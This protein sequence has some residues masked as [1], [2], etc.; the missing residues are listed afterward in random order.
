MLQWLHFDRQ[1]LRPTKSLIRDRVELTRRRPAGVDADKRGAIHARRTSG[2]PPTPGN[3]SA[4]G[5]GLG[6]PGG[7]RVEVRLSRQE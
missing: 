5:P 1:H 2:S 3:R 4:E 7:D 6:V